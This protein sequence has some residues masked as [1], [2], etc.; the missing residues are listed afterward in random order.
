VRALPARTA[1]L[2][3]TNSEAGEYAGSPARSGAA[4]H[5]RERRRRNAVATDR[6]IIRQVPLLPAQPH[7][8]E[9]SLPAAGAGSI[10][11]SGLARG[12]L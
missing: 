3:S 6:L 2:R 10:R 12:V 11:R 8:L 5:G 9:L 7:L 4:I 1:Y